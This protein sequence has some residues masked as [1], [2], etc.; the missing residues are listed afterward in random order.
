M[1][2]N[3]L[4]SVPSSGQPVWLVTARTSGKRESISRRRRAVFT[5]S[6]RDTDVGST[7]ALNQMFP[8]SRAGRNYDPTVVASR[9]VNAT[10]PSAATITSPA[11]RNDHCRIGL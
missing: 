7:V 8:S 9:R 10:Q 2:L 3:K 1:L 5:D 4:G 11:F 6:S